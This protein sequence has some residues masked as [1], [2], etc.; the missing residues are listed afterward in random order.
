MKAIECEAPDFYRIAYTPSGKLAGSPRGRLRVLAK[1]AQ[2][3]PAPAWA[4]DE[5]PT[6]RGVLPREK[7]RPTPAPVTIARAHCVSA[8]ASIAAT[9]GGTQM[10]GDRRMNA[11]PAV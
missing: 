7:C 5:H 10:I 1:S 3:V 9:R 4:L 2:L 8:P 6:S 11:R